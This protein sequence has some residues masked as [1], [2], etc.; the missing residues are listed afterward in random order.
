[1]AMIS[2]R[3]F[4][5]GAGAAGIAL[6]GPGRVHSLSFAHRALAGQDDHE[7][8][9]L[10]TVFLR[11]GAD[12]LNLVVPSDGDDRSLYEHARPNLQVPVA[13]LLALGDSPFGLH[14]SAAPL[15]DLFGDGKL[16]VVLGAGLPADTRSH[17]DAQRFIE[18]GG[19][20]NSGPHSGWLARHLASAPIGSGGEPSLL[21]AIALGSNAPESFA[22]NNQVVALPTLS[23]FE[24]P[25]EFRNWR[26]AQR[27]TLRRLY[28]SGDTAVHAAGLQALNGSNI[29]ELN[30]GE[31]Y[32]PRA[33]IDYPA[34]GF[35]RGLSSLA[36]LIKLD[37]GLS[38]A[39]IDLGGWDT[40][41]SQGN[42]SGGFFAQ[43]VGTLAQG[44]GAFYAD[45]DGPGDSKHIN[46][47][48]IVV[49][50]EF[51]RRLRE[52][53]GGTDHGHGGTMFVLGGAVNGGFHGEWPGLAKERLYDQADL[54]VT[55]DYR[56]VLSEIV[57]RKFANPNLGVVF[58]GYS[59]YQPLG[60]VTGD[61]LD[62]DYTE[63][64]TE[65]VDGGSAS[66]GDGESDK[67]LPLIAGGVGLGAVAAGIGALAL[68]R[69]QT[70]GA[71]ESESTMQD[72]ATPP[73]SGVL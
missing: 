24:F 47:T 28:A 23:G 63:A 40:H 26:A 50:S 27:T 30:S 72:S 64:A 49:M 32:Q 18:I 43:N 57:I 58:P 10:I 46:N 37:L 70:A 45:L 51:G 60:L 69:R 39:T 38:T 19:V 22:T 12:F 9:H 11:G 34:N 55:T 6:G 8:K 20:S 15:A 71:T 16:A 66:S 68:R 48:T 35:G 13:E 3:S 29:I 31:D 73:K 41:A 25:P 61:D 17:F 33:G 54:A 44:L 67:T 1:M 21:P 14:P 52:N 36:R 42:G 7:P 2:R 65:P 59:E 53:S 62:P 5:A 4:I 56:R